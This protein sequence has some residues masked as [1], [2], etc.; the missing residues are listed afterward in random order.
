MTDFPDGSVPFFP[1]GVRIHDDRVRGFKVLL[2]PERALKLDMTGA[3]I[4]GE[5]NGD[6]SFE[7][8]VTILANRYNAPAEQIG[9][10]A[11]AYLS[12]LIDRRMMEMRA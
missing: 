1:R 5:V 8:I 6:R 9:K 10:D 12:G 3:A 7:E 11:R 4:L 2:A